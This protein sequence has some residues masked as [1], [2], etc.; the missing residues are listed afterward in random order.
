MNIWDYFKQG[1]PDKDYDN[2]IK[3]IKHRSLDLHN[4]EN[5]DLREDSESP[6][7][8]YSCSDSYDEWL[9]EQE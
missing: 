9:A 6:R 3:Y 2:H 5:E 1:K 4:P 7:E 8:K